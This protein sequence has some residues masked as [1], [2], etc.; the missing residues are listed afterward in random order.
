[1]RGPLE[2]V[3]NHLSALRTGLEKTLRRREAQMKFREIIRDHPRLNHLRVRE[4]LT[5]P[6]RTL[7]VETT[8]QAAVDH[9]QR[10]GRG[11]YLVVDGG[12]NREG[13]CT[14]TDLHNALGGL[15]PPTTPLS[16]IMSRPVL[17]V[18][19]SKS[20]AEAMQRFLREPVKQLVVVAEDDAERPVG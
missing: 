6:V 4:A 20:L 2:D 1:G 12:G 8:F 18:S 11:A 15:K 10:E 16:E 5:E 7:P 9:F 19:A 14:T 17:T 13:T 3:I